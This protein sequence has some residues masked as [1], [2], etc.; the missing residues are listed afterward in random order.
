MKVKTLNK[1]GYK[2]H[3]INN[4]SFKTISLKIVFW[5]DLIKEDL[6]LRNML[7]NNL[8]FSSHKYDSNRN[9]ESDISWSTKQIFTNNYENY[10]D[11]ANHSLELLKVDEKYKIEYQECKYKYVKNKESSGELFLFYNPKKMTLYILESYVDKSK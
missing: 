7:V 3:I 5:N 9:L 2:L 10:N 1:D 8:L 6:A 11:V 4:S